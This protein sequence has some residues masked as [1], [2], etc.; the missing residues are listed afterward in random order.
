MDN[1]EWIDCT[2]FNEKLLNNYAIGENTLENKMV[3]VEAQFQTSTLNDELRTNIV[4]AKRT[5]NKLIMFDLAKYNSEEKNQ[6]QLFN[7]TVE[8]LEDDLPF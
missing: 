1:D 2:I 6:P 3:F 7:H 5:D 4:V 8:A